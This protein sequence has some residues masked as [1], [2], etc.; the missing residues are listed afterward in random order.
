MSK[1][2]YYDILEV[3]K[4]SDINE[5]KK[6]YKKLALQYHPDKNMGNAEAEKKFKEIAEAYAVLSDPDKKKMYDLTGVTDE[7]YNGFDDVDPFTVFNNIF[8]SHLDNIMNMK[9]EKNIN[10]NDILNKIGSK[11]N[12]DIPGG[13]KFTVHT[14]T[15]SDFIKTEDISNLFM[16]LD[17]VLNDNI[18]SKDILKERV[19]KSYNNKFKNMKKYNDENNE[20]VKFFKKPPILEKNLKVEIVDILNKKSKKIKTTRKRLINGKIIDEE[21]TFKIPIYD[22]YIILENE[23]NELEKYDLLGDLKINIKVKNTQNFKKINKHDLLHIKK[24][25]M[26]DI[27]KNLYY[28]IILPNNEKINV[29]TSPLI[30]SKYYPFIQK[31]SENGLPYILNN[32]IKYGDLYIMYIIKFNKN[33]DLINIEEE[34]D[35]INYKN[36]LNVKIDEIFIN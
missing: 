3:D 10:I 8:K 19:K 28:E 29:K 22:D 25:D 4:N 24:I 20:S 13:I 5:I 35:N 36:A 2:S 11:D 32:D 6:N 15:N 31:I 7:L 18:N 21:C 14:F 26:N 30:L 34:G 1:K 27:Y 17:D 12:F 33:E 16:N 23:G 9:Y